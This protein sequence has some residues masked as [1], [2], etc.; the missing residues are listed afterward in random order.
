MVQL[1]SPRELETMAA[2]GTILAG[3]HEA[4][5]QA[6]HA[7]AT[8]ADLDRVADVFIRSHDGAVPSFKGLYGFPASICA[9]INEEIVHGIPSPRRVLREGDIVSVDIGV[10]YRGLHTDAARTWPVGRVDATTERLLRVT[11]DALRAGIAQAVLGNHIG[12]IGA[13]IESVVARG[14]FSVVRELVGHGVGRAMHEEPQVPN[15]GKPK[16]G[17]RLVEG[18]TLA[19]E[20]MVNAGAAGTRTLGDKW[21]VATADGSRSAHFEH[22]VAIT[23]DGPRVLTG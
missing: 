23:K 16:R 17:M 2:G 4:V 11:Q 15:Y 1:K 21:T 8:T 20:P 14:G 7:G 10:L 3:A 22:T 19:I 5:R 12:D 6:V 9:S 18:L 13:A